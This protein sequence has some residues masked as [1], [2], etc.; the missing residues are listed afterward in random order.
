MKPELLWGLITLGA[1]VAVAALVNVLAPQHRKQLRRIVILY[2]LYALCF[3]ATLGFDAFGVASATK[4][5]GVAAAI[6]K[7]WVLVSLAGTFAF[8]VF[9]PRVRVTTPVIVRDLVVLVGYVVTTLVVLSMNGLDPQGALVSGAV[10][11]A[12]LAISL[13]S[14]LGNLLGG[15]ALQIDGSVHEGDWI[16][17]EN[18]KQGKVRAV[19]W[20]HT[21]IETRDWSTIVVPNS[22][23]LQGSIT[24]LGKR[25]GREVPQRLWVWF[26]VD[27]R[28]AP[29]RVIDVVTEALQSPIDNVSEDPRPNVVCM[30]F[31]KDGK[32]SFAT[33]AV[34]Y[35]IKDL[36]ADDPTNTRIR[37]RVYTALHRAKIPLAIPAHTS[38]WENHDARWKAS[39]HARH[40]EERIDALR[41][42]SLFKPLSDAELATLA[43][44][45]SHVIYCR[46][47]IITRQ[48]AVA[49]WLYVMTS[50]SVDVRVRHDPD[51]DGP[52][53]EQNATVATIRAPGFFGEAGLMTGEPRG[54]DVI[55]AS[56]VVCFRLG[57]ETFEK[58]L[59][60]R[61][62]IADELS[63][64]L[65]AR[66]VELLAVREGLDVDSMRVRQ[67]SE[68]ERILKGIKGF[69]G[70]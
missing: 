59:L 33:Y 14:T 9:L 26:N 31:S 58:V 64:T 40:I 23:L 36:A 45:M 62:E 65:A 29:S 17:L 22:V 3:A 18:G 20:R 68:R 41:T 37:Q 42:V 30:D 1:L 25:E 66:R 48:G 57:K 12:V 52:V 49:H 11:S 34:R 10:V 67:E 35:W 43:E 6:L 16:Q 2:V 53:N 38:L 7:W 5:F 46:G 56:D 63:N 32:E 60:A 44:G 19:R 21:V 61:P 51:G 55:A 4:G 69:F 15:V 13:Q 54:A 50:G 47:E 39:R 8:T 70:L 24:L 27:F 28:W